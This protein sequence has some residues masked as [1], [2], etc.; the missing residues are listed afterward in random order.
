MIEVTPLTGPYIRDA[1]PAL[2]DLRIRVFREWPYLYD[3]SPEYE[4]KYLN[5]F[6]QAKDALI[7][8]ARDSTHIV[9]ASTASPLVGHADEFAEPFRQRGYEPNDVFYFGESVLLPEYR[10][11][12]IGH[13]FFDHR[14]KHARQ[15]EKFKT[16]AFCAVTRS[17]S[18]PRKPANYF[19]LDTF[20]SRRGFQKEEKI[21][22]SLGWKEVDSAGSVP[23]TLQFWIKPL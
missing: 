17:D 12:G 22:A 11:Q 5:K 8:I 21:A 19:P 15:M 23:H 7:V 3:G 14:E 9:G 10:G 13:A 16:A 18:D 20:W 2:A 6:S 4:E 1:L